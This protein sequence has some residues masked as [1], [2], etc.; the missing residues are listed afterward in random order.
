MRCGVSIFARSRRDLGAAKS[1]EQRAATSLARLWLQR[2]KT[3]EA[4]EVLAPVCWF[5]GGFETADLKD[6]KAVLDE[7][8]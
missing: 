3:T 2:A 8:V 7:S 4:C 5:T 1:W 6:E